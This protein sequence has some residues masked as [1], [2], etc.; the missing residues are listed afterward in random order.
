MLEAE[1]NR[2][3]D[4][5]QAF[6]DL[7]SEMV[8]RAFGFVQRRSKLTTELLVKT[9]VLGLLE[10]GDASLTDLVEVAGRLG[11][12][13]SESGFAQRLNKGAEQVLKHLVQLGIAQLAEATTHSGAVLRSFSAVNIVDST[14][15]SLPE[16]CRELFSGSGGCAS[17]ASAKVQVNYEYLSGTFTGLEVSSGRVPDQHCTFPVAL[18]KKTV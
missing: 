18:A 17:E 13:L 12:A 16:R 4:Y 2:V 11:I 1:C 7:P 6:F 8:G 10:K 9:L 14:Q 15:V 5:L 3:T